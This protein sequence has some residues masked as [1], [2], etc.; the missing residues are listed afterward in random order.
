MHL[1]TAL[2]GPL[3]HI[4]ERARTLAAAGFDGVF[5]F[6]GNSDIFFPLVLA[7][8]HT[9]L[10]IATNVAIGFPRSPMHLAYQAWDLQRQSAG[11]F[12]LGLGTQIRPHIERRFSATWGRP[13][14]HMRELV[15]A[16]R[17][18][19]ACWQHGTPLDVHGEYYDLD[20]MTPLFVPEA[21]PSGPPPIWL[22]ALGPRMTH[23]AGEVADGVWVHP[24][25]TRAFVT[26]HTLPNL[27]AGADAA[28]RTGAVQLGIGVMVG[29]Y[30]D[31]A[32]RDPAVAGCRANLA[33]YGSTPAYRVTLDTHGWGDLQPE[34]RRL[35]KE[36]RWDELGAA[37][38]DEVLHT[39]A[40]IGTPSECARQLR[41]R[42]G[43]VADRLAFTLP[44]GAEPDLLAE[45]VAACRAEL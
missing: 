1:H 4:P 32:E 24:F 17:A 26:D 13:V 19:F 41:D 34:L 18:I 5:T 14:A 36:N 2:L 40:V 37:I 10:E 31:D 25:N 42:Y 27:R 3:D 20:L 45:L 6:E 12:S 33:F 7:A 29:V 9:D 16:V 15:E 44:Y 35:T 22:G 11:R 39:I 38:D 28:G 30:R 43:D 8:E 21:L 23:M